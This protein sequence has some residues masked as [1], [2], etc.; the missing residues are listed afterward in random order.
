LVVYCLGL[1]DELKQAITTYTEAGG[2]GNTVIDQ[3]EAVAEE[4]ENIQGVF[5]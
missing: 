3:A 2:T 1:A 4:T 5:S